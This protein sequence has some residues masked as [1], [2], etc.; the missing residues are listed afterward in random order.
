[1]TLLHAL[2]LRKTY[3][4][5][6]A[7][8]GVDLVV[9]R[10]QVVAILG[11]NGAGKTTLIEL[12]LGLRTPDSG[13][14]TLF[15]A[16]PSSPAVKARVGV[17]LQDT[18]VPDALT[19]REVIALVRRYYPVAL[20]VDELL[21]R[22]DLTD[23]AAWRASRLSG[24]QR[25]RLSFAMAIA[26]DP[27]L[28]FLDEPTAALDVTARR[29]FWQQV[30]GFAE[31]GKTVLYST[32]HMDEVDHLADR[33]VVINNGLVIADGSPAYIK[34]AVAARQIRLRTDAPPRLLAEL[35][36]VI[37][38]EPVAGDERLVIATNTPEDVLREMFA[39]GYRVAD[40][41]VAD[42]DLE[43]AFVHLTSTSGEASPRTSAPTD[44]SDAA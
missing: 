40:L 8:D 44:R 31:L 19:V 10:G 6:R 25:Q 41:V 20:P 35:P 36:G 26:G 27:D 29:S 18:D 2:T 33:V 14:V 9:D 38:V 1:M 16:R 28:L 13:T 12:L 24:G 22:A 15:G 11:P 30:R 43:S 32:H 3:G 23:K 5:V 17:M 42:A 34:A 7:V 39:S 21:E 4:P 37:R